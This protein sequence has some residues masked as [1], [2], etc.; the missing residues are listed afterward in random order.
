MSQQLRQVLPR[1]HRRAFGHGAMTAALVIV[2]VHSARART[3]SAPGDGVPGPRVSGGIHAVPDELPWMVRLST[4]AGP[5]VD[6]TGTA[7]TSTTRRPL[8]A[9]VPAYRSV[10]HLF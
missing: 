3:T 2:P 5:W 4:A 1:H 10:S 9:S 7:V 8:L 6:P